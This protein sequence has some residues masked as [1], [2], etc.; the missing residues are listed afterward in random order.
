MEHTHTHTD[1]VASLLPSMHTQHMHRD[2]C[3]H[4]HMRTRTHANTHTHTHTLPT[5]C[6]RSTRA[7]SS[8]WF[9]LNQASKSS[10]ELKTSGRRKLRS[11]HSSW[12]LFC[13][14]VPVRRRRLV[15]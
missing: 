3:T 1:I 5:L 11:A 6:N 9:S 14:G 7:W 8:N 15:L 12:R 10:E 4:T 13:R 2:T